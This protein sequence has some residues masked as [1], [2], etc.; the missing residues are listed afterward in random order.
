MVIALEQTMKL[1]NAKKYNYAFKNRNYTEL[2][3]ISSLGF[4]FLDKKQIY[5]DL[6]MYLDLFKTGD[7]E[8]LS[9][10]ERNSPGV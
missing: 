1:I 7:F 6:H 10:F 4:L 8:I 9:L 3:N 2:Y 5:G